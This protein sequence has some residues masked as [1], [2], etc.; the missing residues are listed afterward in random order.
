MKLAFAL[1]DTGLR[2]VKPRAAPYKLADGGGLFAL[3]MP[4]GS[5]YWRFKF[6]FQGKEK[7]LA[8]GQYPAVKLN[9]ARTSHQTAKLNLQNGI[10]PAAVRQAERNEAAAQMAGPPPSRQPFGKVADDWLDMISKPVEGKEPRSTKTR[11]RDE[12]MVRYIKEAFGG[13]PLDEVE[14]HH[15]VGLL[16][17]FEKAESYET[18]SRLQ[19]AAVNI[20]GFAQGKALIKHNPFIGVAF[21]KAFTA[22]SGTPR[23]AIV[24]PEQFGRLLTDIADYK[25]REGGLVRVALDLLA[26]T[27]VRPGTITNAQWSDFNLDGATWTIPFSKLKQ[28]RKRAKIK[29]LNGQPHLVPLARQTVELLRQLNRRT[30]NHRYLFPGRKDGP[31][32]TAALEMALKTMGYQD[33]HVPH[34]FRSSASTLLHA[35]RITVEGNELPRFAEQA[36]E[37]QLEHVDGSVAAIYNR[38]QRL[39]ERTKIMQFWADRLDLLRKGTPFD[40]STDSLR[41]VGGTTR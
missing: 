15:L 20:G 6:R 26:L 10:N 11:D 24:D 25:A 39:A 32:T 16:N 4:N 13:V 21:G 41:V 1:T 3:V 22:A 23:P 27:F 5:I 9:E 40:D 8:L 19:S 17:T 37:F 14:A 31:I 12:R 2:R 18:R 33:V 30:G 34:G 28:R 35:Q 29:E 36:I 7:T 38:D